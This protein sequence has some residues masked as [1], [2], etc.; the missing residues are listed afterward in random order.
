[1]KACAAVAAMIAATTLL[2]LAAFEAVDHTR[3][4]TSTISIQG[5]NRP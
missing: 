5:D 4:H 1:V 3:I 2:T